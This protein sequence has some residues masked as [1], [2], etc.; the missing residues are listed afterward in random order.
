[1]ITQAERELKFAVPDSFV[2]PQIAPAVG[3]RW[4]AIEPFEM[5]AVYHDTADL[6][7][8][9]WGIT[10]RR[11]WGGPDEGWH[12]KI[13][14]TG[15]DGFTREELHLPL[16]AGAAGFVPAE[17]ADI[18][19]PLIRGERLMPLATVQ[20][21]RSPIQ[22]LDEQ[23]EPRAEIVD[24]RVV[25]RDANGELI[26]EFREVEVEARDAI[27]DAAVLDRLADA[28]T[29]VGGE[30]RTASKAAQALGPA[31]AQPPDVPQPDFPG[32]SGSVAG[33]LA[34][35]FRT[36]VRHL[37]FADMAWR[38]DLP[39]A[40]HQMRVATRRLRS[41]LRT[42]EPLLQLSGSWESGEGGLD[43]ELAWLAEELGR[44][45]DT[46]VLREHLLAE[47]QD[48]RD[49]EAPGPGSDEAVALVESQ[50]D[51]RM[52][53]ARM[54]A[55]AAVRSDRY[56][57][58]LDD[59]VQLAIEPPMSSTA[60][61]PCGL[62]LPGP[63]WAQWRALVKAMKDLEPD[64]PA[65]QWHRVRIK[66]K[67]ARYAAEALAPILG[68]PVHRLAVRLSAI[69]DALGT[70]QD[71]H[72]A[73]GFITELVSR[74]QTSAGAAFALGHLHAREVS[75]EITARAEALEA[76]PAARKAAKRSGLREPR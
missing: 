18:V 54:G 7:L 71:A 44:L 60:F 76:W 2:M 72:V 38:R 13:P 65:T 4:T 8:I 45:R 63:V 11:R 1:M 53:D 17:M 6:R 15:S 33:A 67:R 58:L 69:T 75:R 48:V 21:H 22:I 25:V 57:Q 34:A 23:G 61:G 70:G 20:T 66:A 42:F 49:I 3:M 26:A 14:L 41:T 47:I 24:D 19:L 35:M 73:Q 9:R 31:V 37:L 51:A 16:S 39:D 64:A 29:A 28:I 74:P 30:Q 68:S 62:V 43:G 32:P 36:H 50:L 10:L 46:E 12:L 55:L 27:R 5:T 56:L 40:V 52:A 59:L